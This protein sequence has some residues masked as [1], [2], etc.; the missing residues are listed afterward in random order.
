MR[1]QILLKNFGVVRGPR[2]TYKKAERLLEEVKNRKRC[3]PK[4][5]E[6]KST[7]QKEDIVEFYTKNY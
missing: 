4:S 5:N 2:K 1:W 7:F 3:K 6:N